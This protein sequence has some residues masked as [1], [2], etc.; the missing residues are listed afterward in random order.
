MITDPKM[1]NVSSELNRSK[2]ASYW[3]D[4]FLYATDPLH[5]ITGHELAVE[6]DACKAHPRPFIDSKVII[7]RVLGR[8]SNTHTFHRQFSE[9]FPGLQPAQILGMQL[10]TIVLNDA[11]IWV[12]VETH[13]L[14]H[15]FPNA[16]YFIPRHVSRD[17]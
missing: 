8:L 6:V 11:E 10:Y 7:N 15:V 16:T 3:D 9:R 1:R 2:L 4:Y 14:G 12:Y 13:H 17:A 5:D